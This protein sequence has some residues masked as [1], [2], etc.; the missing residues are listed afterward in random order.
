MGLCLSNRCSEHE[1][2]GG[3]ATYWD[4]LSTRGCDAS[5]GMMSDICHS[6]LMT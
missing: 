1:L 4:P 3:V 6:I 5:G 2:S